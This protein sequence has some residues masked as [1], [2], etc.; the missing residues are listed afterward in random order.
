MSSDGYFDDE[1]DSAFLKEVDAIEAAHT[2]QQSSTIIS[3]NTQSRASDTRA[4]H[5]VIEIDDEDDSF[6]VF[7]VNAD[8]LRHFDE[9][10]KNGAPVASTSKQNKPHSRTSSRG[11]VQTT[12]FGE[13]AVQNAGPSRATTTVALQRTHSDSR[14]PTGRQKKTKKWDH[15]SFAK[16]SRTRLKGKG[17]LQQDAGEEEE[18]WDDPVEFVQFPAPEADPQPMKLKPDLLAARRWIYPLNKPK[19]DYQYNIVKHCLFDNTLVA[20]PTGLGKTF[21]AGVVMLN[22]YTWFPEGKVVFVGPTK[23]LV[24]QQIDACHKACGIPGSHAAEL[25]G[26]IPSVKRAKLWQEK[27]VFFMTPQTLMNDLKKGNCDPQDIVLFVVDEAHK[28]TGDYAYA[29]AVRYLM[30]KNPHFRVLAL[31]ATPGSN[32]EAV[33]E[34]VDSLHISHVEIRDEQ[35]LDIRSYIHKKIVEQVIVPMTDEI[36]KVRDMLADLMQPMIKTVQ[37]V[38]LLNGPSDPVSLHYFR[39]HKALQDAHGRRDKPTFAFAPLKNLSALARAMGYLLEASIR[40]CLTCLNELAYGIDTEDGGGPKK[41]NNKG[42][43]LS[44]DPKF[45]AILKEL[46][47]IVNR[48]V[49]HPKMDK[50]KS[51]L[52]QHFGKRMCEKE[53]AEAKGDAEAAEDAASSRVMVFASFRDSIE[54]IVDLLN[55]ESPLIRAAKFIG[56]GTDKRGQKGYAQKEQIEVINKFKAGVYNVLVSTSIGEEGLDIGEVEAIICYDAQKTPIRMLQRIGRTGRKRD[57]YV[58]VLL[59][60]GREDRNWDK[61]KDMYAMVQDFIV[62]ADQLELF[63]DVERMIPDHIRPECVEMVMDIE[64]YVREEAGS[65]SKKGSLANSPKPKK[66]KRNDDM[67]RNIPNGASSTFV[68]VR[69]LIAKGAASRKRKKKEEGLGL[70]LIASST[71][72]DELEIEAGLTGPRRVLSL[73]TEKQQ[74]QKQ[75]MSRRAKTLGG[76]TTPNKKSNS[77]KKPTIGETVDRLSHI[78]RDD[79]DDEAIESGNA[80]YSQPPTP[81][82]R[83]NSPIQDK[84]DRTA[85]PAPHLTPHTRFSSPDDRNHSIIDLTTPSTVPRALSPVVPDPPNLLNFGTARCSTPAKEPVRGSPELVIPSSPSPSS[86]SLSAEQLGESTSIAWLV[87]NDSEPEVALEKAELASPARA[88]VDGGSDEELDKMDSVHRSPLPPASMYTQSPLSSPIASRIR[89]SGQRRSE[90]DM[91]P[92]ALPSRFTQASELVREEDDFELPSSTFVVRPPGRS[93]KRSKRKILADV[94]DVDSSPVEIVSPP[95]RRL[96]RRRHSVSP[97]PE[98]RPPKK[99]RRFRD[100]MEAQQ[101]NP[102]LDVEATHSGD[103]NSAGGSGEELGDSSDQ[104]FVRELPE[105]QVSSSYDQSAV[106]RQSLLS[107]A[108]RNAGNGPRFAN[109]P[110][111]KGPLAYNFASSSRREQLS[112][113]S[114]PRNADSDDYVLGSFIVPDDAD[115]SYD[116]G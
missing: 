7:E 21:I 95:K 74:P 58:F 110:V 40:Q 82:T 9:V 98:P 8:E 102:W 107:Q 112:P 34:I 36:A 3:H 91:P 63:N 103:D 113:P 23:P 105:S 49:I 37:R 88:I 76:N 12:L 45:Q 85:S 24:A 78:R 55:Q 43:K 35:S 90:S 73:T 47:S 50:T 52:V 18:G 48:D 111:R 31:T 97:S 99:K 41:H 69:E 81:R 29:Q 114:S 32:P 84:H 92:P 25:T 46:E 66:R 115:I 42:S 93:S 79:S 5:D 56:Q 22:Y 16:S 39:A 96:Q 70:Q 19:R 44:K 71:D 101:F 1:L 106:Y 89:P 6:G 77:R 14:I 27:R 53:E 10:C 4:R 87:E 28:A 104:E 64:E 17:K 57:G 51:L 116:D 61:A 54:Q 33:Q 13:V 72:E 109:K 68:S 59:A 30:Q 15:A 62:R 65:K 100:V 83:L 108:P 38:N 80:D 67:M 11:T 86:R 26:E 60:E 20:L 94:A 75:K 2:G